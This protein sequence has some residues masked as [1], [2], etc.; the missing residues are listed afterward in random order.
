MIVFLMNDNIAFL[1]FFQLVSQLPNDFGQLVFSS[2]VFRNKSSDLG[3]VGLWSIELFL[4]LFNS[5]L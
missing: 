4:G 5:E 3:M 1:D 2:V